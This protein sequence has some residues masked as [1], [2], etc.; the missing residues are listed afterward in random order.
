[1][2]L[3]SAYIDIFIRG[4]KSGGNVQGEMSGYPRDATTMRKSPL[5]TAYAPWFI[6]LYSLKRTIE[7]LSPDPYN[8]AELKAYNLFVVFKFFMSVLCNI[9]HRVVFCKPLLR[10]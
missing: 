6:T 4:E 7:T 9:V 8:Y 2:T 1:M 10:L 5:V 3:I